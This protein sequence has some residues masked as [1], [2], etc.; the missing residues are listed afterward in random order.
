LLRIL[1]FVLTTLLVSDIVK[2]V[3]SG[4]EGSGY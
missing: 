3:T 1:L 2:R 4:G